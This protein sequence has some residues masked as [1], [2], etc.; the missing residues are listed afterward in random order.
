ME[1]QQQGWHCS[2]SEMEVASSIHALFS[3]IHS[4]LCSCPSLS[5]FPPPSRLQFSSPFSFPCSYSVTWRRSKTNIYKLQTS[6]GSSQKDFLGSFSGIAHFQDSTN[7]KSQETQ[8]RSKR[9][10]VQR[11][12]LRRG[13]NLMKPALAQSSALFLTVWQYRT[14]LCPFEVCICTQMDRGDS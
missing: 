2:C 7:T 5:R 9:L 12:A 8:N 10:Q 11:C 1:S 13:T 14:A 3:S 6:H 4:L